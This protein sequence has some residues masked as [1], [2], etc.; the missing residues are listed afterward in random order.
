LGLLVLFLLV[1]EVEELA[2]ELVEVVR[3]LEYY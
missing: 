2:V 3:Q 1:A